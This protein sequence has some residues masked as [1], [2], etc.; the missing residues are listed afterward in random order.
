AAIGTL[1]GIIDTAPEPHPI[2]PLIKILKSHG[3]L[4]MVCEPEKPAEMHTIP[5]LL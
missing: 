4:I 5:V 2:M 3:K 1:D